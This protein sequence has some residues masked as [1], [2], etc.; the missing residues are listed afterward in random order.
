MW[1]DVIATAMLLQSVEGLSDREVLRRLET[2][3][4]RQKAH[5]TDSAESW[6]SRSGR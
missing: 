5:A 3:A 6:Q 1:A 2:R 4:D